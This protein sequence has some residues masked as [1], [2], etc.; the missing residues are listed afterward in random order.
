VDATYTGKSVVVLGTRAQVAIYHQGKLLEVHA[1]ITDPHQ[2]KATK[3]QHLK[4]W[5]RSMQDDSFYRTRAQA[6]GPHVDALILQ[7][8][9]RG[10]GFIDTRKIWGI[11]SLDK[12]YPA[13]QIDAAC[14]RALELDQLSFR[15]VKR[16]VE[17]AELA[18][19]AP[20]AGP[21]DPRRPAAPASRPAHKH[22]RPLS[23]Y[24][25]QLNLFTEDG[26]TGAP[27]VGHA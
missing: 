24:R 26:A 10:Q 6:L 13:H 1:R 17:L 19:L 11:L 25:E 3:P 9:A 14:R 22:V 2:A 4:P 18:A 20:G 27:R 8:L 21:D 7:L 16:Y 5:E 12:R 23:V 15:V